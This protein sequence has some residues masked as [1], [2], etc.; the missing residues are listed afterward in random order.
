MNS[1][2]NINFDFSA[3]DEQALAIAV[4]GYLIVFFALVML[5]FVFNS[6][7]R[8]LGLRLKSRSIKK[9]TNI[10]DKDHPLDLPGEVNAAIAMALHLH[11]NEL[12]DEE[13]NV[14]TIKRISKAYSPWSSKIYAVRNQFNRI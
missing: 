3:L 14:V 9:G 1:L 8:I 2:I 12:H 13:S 11:F 4:V 5:F 10:V 7:P 6:L